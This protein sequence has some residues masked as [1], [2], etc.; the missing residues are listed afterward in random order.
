MNF[1][2]FKHTAYHV[3]SVSGSSYTPEAHTLVR[4]ENVQNAINKFIE[5]APHDQINSISKQTYHRFID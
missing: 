4:A 3:Y 5:I 1:Y 2:V